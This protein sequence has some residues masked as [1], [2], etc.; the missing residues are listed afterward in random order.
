[1]SLR[2]A[3]K[4]YRKKYNL[5]IKDISYEEYRDI[6]NL[7]N[8]KV[9]NYVLE[10]KTVRLPHSM[11]R[12]KIRKRLINL[13]YP[14]IDFNAT[15]IARR[16]DPNAKAIRHLNFHSDG[17]V[18][19]WFWYRYKNL[20]SNIKNFKFVPSRGNDGKS[21]VERLAKIMNKEDG[22]KRYFS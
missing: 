18:A 22:H 4:S 15:N 14:P 3:Y 6:S 7:F 19:K 10:G 1:M 16:K 9:S 8:K 11:G 21:N 5:S 17:F 13:D 20:V 12:L 2:K